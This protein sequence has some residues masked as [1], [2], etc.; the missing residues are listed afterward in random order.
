M[1]TATITYTDGRTLPFRDHPIC[2]S[3]IA[4]L[5]PSTVLCNRLTYTPACVI[6]RSAAIAAAAS[7][8]CLIS[9]ALTANRHRRD[10]VCGW[11]VLG[12]DGWFKGF[13]RALP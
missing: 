11:S 13:V 12:T 6:T 10:T 2:G 9:C 7:P 3:A 1:K 5:L 4:D 8:V